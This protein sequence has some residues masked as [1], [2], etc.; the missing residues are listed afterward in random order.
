MEIPGPLEAIKAIIEESRRLDMALELY[1]RVS[2]DLA[3][4][5]AKHYRQEADLK[6]EYYDREEKASAAGAQ[7]FADRAT[8]K[9]RGEIGRLKATKG[10]AEKL[11]ASRRDQITAAESIKKAVFELEEKG[12]GI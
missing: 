12:P 3:E 7:D 2:K 6:N 4:L 9:E 8:A 11:V 1:L 10:Y 5:E